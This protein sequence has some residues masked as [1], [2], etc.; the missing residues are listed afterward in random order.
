MNIFELFGSISLKGAAE[1]EKQLQGIEGWA[2]KNEQALKAMG[3]VMTGAGVA[4]TGALAFATKAALDEDINIQH[5]SASLKN[6]GTNYDSVKD[7]LEG[8]ITATQRKTGIADSEQR[9]ILSRL[10]LVTN[11]YNK[12]LK[13]LPLS[14]DLAAAGQMD[15]NSAATYLA[16][17]MLDLENGA[18]SVSIRL[19]QATV[20][21]RSLQEIQDRVG[22][23]AEA[24]AN[25]LKILTAELGD[26]A[27]EIG[28]NLLPMLKDVVS[29][30]VTAVGAV[31]DWIKE[32]PEAART[33]TLVALAT[34]GLLSFVGPLALLLPKLPVMFT[35]VRLALNLLLGPIGWVTLAITALAGV[36]LI[37]ADN[38]ESIVDP[39]G[40]SIRKITETVK[41]ELNK[42]LTDELNA[43]TKKKNNIQTEYDARVKAI[44]DEYGLLK[45]E[46]KTRQQLAK[47]SSEVAQ[48][49]LQRELDNSRRVHDEKISMLNAEY[50]AKLRTL[51]AETDAQT[52]A[53]QAQIDA[54]DKQ[55]D[56]EG[57]VLKQK[58][59]QERLAELTKA[60]QTATG[61]ESVR[62]LKELNDFKAQ[63][64]RD[65]L[66]QRRDDEK[67]SLRT[68]IENIR[69]SASTQAQIYKDDLAAKIAAEDA[70]LAKVITQTQQME[71]FLNGLFL[72][73]LYRIDAEGKA[74]IAQEDANLKATL[75]YLTK[76]ETALNESY[77]RRINQAAE[78]A[79]R[80]AMAEAGNTST[81]AGGTTIEQ[82]I[83]I[84][85]PDWF[86]SLPG[87]QRG[88]MIT[89]PSLI[90]RLR[91]RKPIAIAGETG[92]ETVGF[93]G[94]T[95]TGNNFYV[96]HESDID[97]IADALIGKIRLKTGMHI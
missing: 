80:R 74:K 35:A 89:E 81:G 37:V 53:L 78:F 31:K 95:I 1:A 83:P 70:K 61:A 84:A 97:K 33:I 68:Q 34:G 19:G 48:Q 36:A 82:P 65:S 28:A 7:S 62:A 43:I 73:E 93:G 39:V 52:K 20:Q 85:P 27:E 47:D 24:M 87:W 2:K 41:A 77:Q 46:A 38:W 90:T 6:V 8:V 21:F 60:Y 88:G 69:A 71:T 58:R 12:A 67:D 45:D 40:A 11:D 26:L 54:I 18:Q 3:A 57:R 10:L 64:E 16:K 96:R 42:Q 49:A 30:I 92:P 91:D 50:D 86:S 56:V 63:I 72:N 22:G 4:I 23:S 66:L 55:T 32:N 79:R 9:D 51:N 15:A 94:V 17:A 25:P 44:H 14:L 5:L 13:L 75:D 59:D 29:K 76:E